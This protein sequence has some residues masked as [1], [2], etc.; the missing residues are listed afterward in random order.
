MTRDPEPVI[1]S[2]DYEFE[3]GRAIVV[4]EGADVALISTGAQTPR[5]LT[6]A[7]RIGE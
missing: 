7:R 6:A 2:A 4:R 1:F 5:C 3:L